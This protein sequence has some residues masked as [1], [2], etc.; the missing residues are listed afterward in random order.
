MGSGDRRFQESVDPDERFNQ[1]VKK[2]YSFNVYRRISIHVG[3]GVLRCAP[4][5]ALQ[6]LKP[7]LL[8]T[9]VSSAHYSVVQFH[10]ISKI[11]RKDEH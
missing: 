6:L 7:Q 10:E 4:R 2:L 9:C 8:R 11:Y 5:T 1:R 3:A